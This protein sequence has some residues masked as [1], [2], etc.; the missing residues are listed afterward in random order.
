M[1]IADWLRTKYCW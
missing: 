1:A